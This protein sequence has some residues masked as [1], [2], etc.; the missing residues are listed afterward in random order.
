MLPL[1]LLSL[2]STQILARAGLERRSSSADLLERCFASRLAL[3]QTKT[4]AR[5]NQHQILT[6]RPPPQNTTVRAQFLGAE[7]G[8]SLSPTRRE[9]SSSS[10]VFFQMLPPP[11][12]S[13]SLPI[14]ILLLSN[15]CRAAHAFIQFRS[16][17]P[18]PSS[19]S[20]C[21]SSFEQHQHNH[22]SP[23]A[24]A[25]TTAT[26]MAGTNGNDAPTLP[27]LVTTAWLAEHIDDEDLAILDVRGEV[28]KATATED[29][30]QAT[31]YK[32]L[33]GDY[34]DAHIPEAAFVDWTKDIAYTHEAVPVQLLPLD[35][36]RTALESKGVGLRKR[37]VI[38]DGGNLLF[39]TRLWW[40]LRLAGHQAV[41]VLDGG[42]AKWLAEDRYI[43]ADAPCPLKINE[44]WESETVATSVVKVSDDYSPPPFLSSRVDADFVL[45]SCVEAL[46]E[47][48]EG[49]QIIDARSRDQ[50]LGRVSRS[51]RAGHI[52]KARSV[53]YKDLLAPA[54][55][56]PKTQLS[57]R[58]MKSK[59]GLEET[60]REA[61]VSVDGETM[62][63][64][65]VYC[66]GGV[67]ST[68]VI[69]VLNQLFG[70]Q[71]RNYDGSWNEWGK[72]EDLPVS[73]AKEEG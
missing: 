10:N 51:L 72:R 55:T 17:S 57:Y 19:V 3:A 25:G 12:P 43:T 49:V 48:A 13:L 61:G 56:H 35:D 39:A 31:E 32:A 34:V 54:E 37:V 8:L 67:A 36:L 62:S 50:Y 30:K 68:V 9:R 16:T 70:M 4:H 7:A 28:A 22:P 41:A 47:E 64:T 42:Y 2:F 71:T 5:A 63:L 29:G 59:E 73:I 38:Y 14:V 21:G 53:P 45:K 1:P 23:F 52:P 60:L 6:T 24:A 11:L 46:P 40:A 27:G 66:N 26:V 58:V 20:S 18:L 33:F 69:F 65:C 44:I 15:C